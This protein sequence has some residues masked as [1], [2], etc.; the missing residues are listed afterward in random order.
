MANRTV[1]TTQATGLTLYAYPDYITLASWSTYRVA[2]TEGT[3]AN[4][5]RYSATISDSDYTLWR[6]FVGSTQPSSWA[7]S[8]ETFDLDIPSSYLTVTASEVERVAGTTI[9]VFTDEEVDITVTLSSGTLTGR[10]LRFVIEDKYGTDV[11]VI[12]DADIDSGATDFTVTI[13]TTA[14]ASARKLRWSLRD[15]DGD[16]VMCHGPFHVVEA[17][18]GDA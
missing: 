3:G 14:T 15:T 13:P 4:I 10:T 6:L 9:T 18:M 2:L 16:V 12:E 11:A 1:S 5:G 7:E 8:I 17:A